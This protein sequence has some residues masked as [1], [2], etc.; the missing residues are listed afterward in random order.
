MFWGLGE[1]L[2]E[3]GIYPLD[4]ILGGGYEKGDIIEVSG[5][6]GLGKTTMVL[7][8]CKKA[9]F[10]GLTIAYLDVE[11]AVKASF[12]RNLGIPLDEVGSVAGEHKFFLASPCNFKELEDIC[13]VLLRDLEVPYDILIIDSLSNVN[14][15]AEN[16]TVESKE[17]GLRARQETLFFSK[18]KPDFR[19]SK[20][21]AVVVNQMRTKMQSFGYMMKVSEDSSGGKSSKHNFDIR[22]RLS[23]GT[24][25]CRKEETILGSKRKGSE[26]TDDQTIYGSVSRLSA[27]KNRNERPDIPV[28][29]HVIYGRGIS[30]VKFVADVITRIE[31]Y[32]TKG[33]GF[34]NFP[35]DCPIPVLRELVGRGKEELETVV[36]EHLEVIVKYLKDIGHWSLVIK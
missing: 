15:F 13:T 18:F 12:F 3:T 11:N 27:I 10:S 26:M 30:N 23:K 8:L 22:L 36:E 19:R 16:L 7:E 17:M 4:I 1:D 33:G 28:N 20:T 32:K 6:T 9:Y 21:T 34:W 24:S 5:D 29:L 14:Q 25:L 2:T 35:D 31:L